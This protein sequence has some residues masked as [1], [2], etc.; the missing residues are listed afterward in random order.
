MSKTKKVMKKLGLKYFSS[1]SALQKNDVVINIR[2]LKNNL[3]DL[4]KGLAI[5]ILKNRPFEKT[6]KELDFI[7]EHLKG[8]KVSFFSPLNCYFPLNIKK[9]LT[10]EQ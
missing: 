10:N 5:E 6:I 1:L 9:I 2:I 3:S 8:Q 7:N 4:P